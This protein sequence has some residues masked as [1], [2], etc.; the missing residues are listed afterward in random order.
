[1]YIKDQCDINYTYNNLMTVDFENSIYDIGDVMLRFTD[2][3]LV[4]KF[5][6]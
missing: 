2:L 1:M 4:M 6:V 3:H 5:K